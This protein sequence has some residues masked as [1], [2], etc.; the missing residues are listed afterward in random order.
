MKKHF[1]LLAFLSAI[2]ISNIHAQSVIAGEIINGTPTL[3]ME[4]SAI[5]K[6]YNS[7]LLKYSGIDGQ[8]TDVSIKS[9]VGNIYFLLFTGKNYRSS[10]ML[11]NNGGKLAPSGTSC[12]TPDCASE[13]HGCEVTYGTGPNVGTVYCSPCGNQ[14]RCI[15]TS[16]NTSLLE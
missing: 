7:N 4:K 15:K 16:T 6:A 8:F 12:T 3:T 11:I 2:A 9:G 5:L 1:V 13:P 14:G 10:L